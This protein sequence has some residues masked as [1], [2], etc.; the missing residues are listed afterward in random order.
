MA[1][2]QPVSFF[3]LAELVLPTRSKSWGSAQESALPPLPPLSFAAQFPAYDLHSTLKTVGPA[4]LPPPMLQVP[5]PPASPVETISTVKTDP[6]PLEAPK[7]ERDSQ[8]NWQTPSQVRAEKKRAAEARR[9]FLARE[10]KREEAALVAELARKRADILRRKA[11]A[12]ARKNGVSE[13]AI[14]AQRRANA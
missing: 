7:P 1:A 9:A 6:P 14:V 3:N 8:T 11:E 4:Y 13:A 12:K 10:K 5:A 2:F